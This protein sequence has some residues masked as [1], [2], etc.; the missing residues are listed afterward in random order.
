M[1]EKVVSKMSEED[2]EKYI[3]ETFKKF[4]PG[5]I[6]KGKIVRRIGNNILVDIGWKAEGIISVDEFSDEEEI[7]EGK[8]IMVFLEAEE[9]KD[10]I[11]VISKKKADFQLAWSTIKEKL[12]TG[13]GCT[14]KVKKR[15]KGGLLVEVFGLDAF[16]PGSQVDIKPVSNFDEYVGKELEVKIIKVNWSKRNIVVSCRMLLEEQL[17]RKRKEFFSKAKEG[18]IVEGT[19]KNIVNFGAFL[20]LDGVDALLHITDISWKKIYHP[21]EVLKVGDRIKVKILSINKE[22]GRVTVGL[23]QLEAHPW[24]D[25][26]KK[27]PIGSRIKGKVTGFTD[28]GAFVELEKGVEGMIHVSEMSWTKSITHPAQVLR[29]GDMV[30][31]VILSIDKDERKISLGLK[32]TMP[33]PWAVIDEKYKV[34]QKVKGTVTEL[35][36]FGA[37]VELEDGIEGLIKN[38]DL[39]WTKKIKHPREVLKKG[40]VIEAMIL[41]IDKANRRISLSLKHTQEDPFYKWTKAHKVG[42]TV[43]GRIIDM[44]SSGV[45]VELR[46][47]LEGFVPARELKQKGK[48]KDNYKLGDMIE[49][50][51]KRIDQKARKIILSEKEH[52]RV[53][54]EKEREVYTM[55]KAPDKFTVKDIIEKKK[56]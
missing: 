33:D 26:E 49:L 10:G 6:V 17:E 40:Q 35:R 11:P 19:V 4:S 31:V 45:V 28:N 32:Q 3:E 24:E 18:D 37:F 20:D 9:S 38:Q 15:V 2:L 50:V 46:K 54:K 44:P 55:K 16:L 47:E 14:A 29:I 43:K 52:E 1:D 27:Y 30:E 53:K 5:E 48:I 51:V 56:K 39:S 34:N 41:A 36:S 13:E 25:I 22:T 23:K 7:E 8:E 21:A 42:S 12:E